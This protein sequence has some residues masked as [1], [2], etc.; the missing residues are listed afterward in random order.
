MATRELPPQQIG[1]ALERDV[2]GVDVE[3]GANIHQAVAAEG[4]FA[5]DGHYNAMG[6]GVMHTFRLRAG[7]GVRIT[8]PVYRQ[9]PQDVRSP[10]RKHR[11]PAVY[12]L[13]S[14]AS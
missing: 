9:L 11:P 8:E 5:P 12:T 7:S 3:I 1:K 2:F 14:D 13:E 10:W 6:T 4:E